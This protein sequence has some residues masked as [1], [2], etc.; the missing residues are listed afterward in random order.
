MKILKEKNKEKKKNGNSSTQSMINAENEVI[1]A[2]SYFGLC[3]ST[4][5]YIVST[6]GV[7]GGTGTLK[8]P[9][10]FAVEGK[11]SL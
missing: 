11:I 5:R 6:V 7:L 8:I 9:Q 10:S 3:V 1:N 2:L 4:V